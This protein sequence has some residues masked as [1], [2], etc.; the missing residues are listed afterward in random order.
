M[1][2]MQKVALSSAKRWSVGGAAACAALLAAPA[3][4]AS[5]SAM[6]NTD[7]D[8]LM[9][10]VGEQHAADVNFDAIKEFVSCFVSQMD[11]PQQ[12]YIDCGMGVVTSAQACRGTV[13]SI[14]C[15]GSAIDTAQ[16]CALPVKDTVDGAREC[17]AEQKK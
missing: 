16:K 5:E 17:M 8:S 1:G 3:A 15:I 7:A 11:L 12:V 13:M 2:L 14:E 6:V 10:L 4:W 9:S